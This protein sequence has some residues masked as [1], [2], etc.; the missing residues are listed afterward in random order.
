MVENKRLR[1]KSAYPYQDFSDWL[2][3]GSASQMWQP[4]V[5]FIAVSFCQLS[6]HI[7]LKAV[8]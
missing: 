7:S 5:Q 3:T 1:L 6:S 4:E 2:L 8:Q